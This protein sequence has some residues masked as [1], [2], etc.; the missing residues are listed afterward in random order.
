WSSDVCSSDLVEREVQ[1]RR[2]G[3]GGFA[4][5]QIE[6]PLHTV[7]VLRGGR[8]SSSLY[9]TAI[10]AGIPIAA[11]WEM[12]RAFSFDVDF[13]RD[14]QPGDRFD[15]LFE[16]LRNEAGDVVNTGAVH[17]ASMTLSGKTMPICRF[18]PRPGEFD[19]Y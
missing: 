1:V 13:Q 11:L 14:I 2:D 18:E 6:F 10:D 9:E 12:V 4:A 3:N 7:T 17:Y 16:E 19:F 8:I 5:E 15:I